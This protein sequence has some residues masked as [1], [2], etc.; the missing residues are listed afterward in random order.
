MVLATAGLGVIVLIGLL[1]TEM[2]S[3]IT[4]AGVWVMRVCNDDV[5]VVD[6]VGV[7]VYIGNAVKQNYEVISCDYI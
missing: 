1:L 6:G 7:I 5:E 2:L 3:S 4:V